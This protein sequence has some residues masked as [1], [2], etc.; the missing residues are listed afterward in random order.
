MKTGALALLALLMLAA[1][2]EDC[3]M[4]TKYMGDVTIR[5]LTTLADGDS[6][7]NDRPVFNAGIEIPFE[8]YVNQPIISISGGME[9]KL[10]LGSE[11]TFLANDTD[12]A[13]KIEYMRAI[14][15][16]AG[17]M[18]N[19]KSAS[20]KFTG[21]ISGFNQPKI[22]HVF[23]GIDVLVNQPL[24]K[25]EIL[26]ITFPAD[27]EGDFEGELIVGSVA[28][29]ATWKAI[30]VVRSL[31]ASFDDNND[32]LF[33]SV[34]DRNTAVVIDNTQATMF[35][36]GIESQ[37]AGDIIGLDFVTSIKTPVIRLPWE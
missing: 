17:E 35:G 10:A 31:T 13:A 36:F 24:D 19:N 20:A 2:P 3:N 14:A 5:K 23:Y 15:F 11:A 1:T 18:G 22:I 30:L 12:G 7:F 33:G 16:V 26:T 25:V 29:Y 28:G 21:Y 9:G 32:I 34:I 37:D 27:F 4:P 8:I 6:T